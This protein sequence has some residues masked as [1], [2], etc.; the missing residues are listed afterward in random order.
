MQ[1]GVLRNLRRWLSIH[2]RR[3]AMGRLHFSIYEAWVGHSL[4]SLSMQSRLPSIPLGAV[5]FL[6]EPA[7]AN[8]SD[9]DIRRERDRSRWPQHHVRRRP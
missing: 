4:R 6:D 7:D 1:I 3:L 5:T 9:G 2:D 8:A